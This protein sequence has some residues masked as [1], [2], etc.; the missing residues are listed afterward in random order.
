MT[1]KDDVDLISEIKDV[2]GNNEETLFSLE[3]VNAVGIGYKETKSKITDELCIKVFVK[4]KLKESALSKTHI[5]PKKIDGIATDVFEIGEIHAQANT[6]KVRPAKPGFS[7]GHFKITAGTFGAIARDQCYPCNYYI[8]S[9]NHVLANSNA[10]AIGD[11]ILQPGRVDGGIN[12][13]DRIA[14]LSK[15]VP[16]NFGNIDLYNLV[17]AAIAKPLDSNFVIGAI[18]KLGIPTGT[19]EASLNMDVIK[20]GRTTGTTAEKVIGID[21]TVAVNYGASG[22]AYFRDQFLTNDMSD[23][24]DSGSLLLNRKNRKAIGLLFAGSSTV[25]IFNNIHNVMMALK[26]SLLT[27]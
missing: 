10:A 23:G 3:N 13:R 9:N 24:G 19:E 1:S 22:T 2:K 6:A 8:L 21:A 7:I 14:R 5:I 18:H 4:Q 15:F 25:T 17:D 20:T 12:P 11:A 27:E 16:I 26:I